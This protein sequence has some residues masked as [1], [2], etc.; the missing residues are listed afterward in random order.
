MPLLVI[1]LIT[2]F[3]S[4]KLSQNKSSRKKLLLLNQK[5]LKVQQIQE[6]LHKRLIQKKPRQQ[7][8]LPLMVS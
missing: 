7:T 5:V 8:R 2:R 1:F 4:L 3:L 6:H